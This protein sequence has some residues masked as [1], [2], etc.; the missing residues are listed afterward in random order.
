MWRADSK[1]AEAL[2]DFNLVRVISHALPPGDTWLAAFYSISPNLEREP[3][4]LRE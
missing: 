4:F 3:G 1:R 2:L